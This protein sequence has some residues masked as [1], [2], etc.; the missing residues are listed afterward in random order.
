MSGLFSPTTPVERHTSESFSNN[1]ETLPTSGMF[2]KEPGKSETL[3]FP[4]SINSSD[5]RLRRIQIN[6]FNPN[7]I[8]E[9][10]SNMIKN[11][12]ENNEDKSATISNEEMDEIAKGMTP[13]TTPLYRIILPLVNTLQET[14]RH[15][16][17]EDGGILSRLTNS[18][19]ETLSTG[20][21]ISSEL[22]SRAGAALKNNDLGAGFAP[23]LPQIDPMKWQNYKGS[24]LRSFQFVFKVS[25]RNIDE[26]SN[27]MNI[28]Y[29]LKKFS[30]PRKIAA[31]QML[32][33]PAR[34]SLE[35]SNPMLQNLIRPGICVI[36]D[37]N[38]NYESGQHIATTFDGIPRKFEF[39]LMLKEFRQKYSD[40]WEIAGAN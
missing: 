12:M 32:I 37:L 15:I 24:S 7:D 25:P 17:D 21:K 1:I 27:I 30:Y 33:P 28:I 26:A 6:I 39:N 34:V 4:D 14:N 13:T 19:N 3:Y 9:R 5:F 11:L 36:E 40:D 20:S 18:I 31:G 23:Q 35:F 2:D 29:I 10:A 22:T 8:F 16:Y 38:V